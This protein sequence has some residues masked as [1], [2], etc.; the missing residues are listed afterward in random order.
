[1]K[2]KEIYLFFFLTFLNDI[3]HITDNCRVQAHGEKFH[4]FPVMTDGQTADD[5][6]KKIRKLILENKK[7]LFRIAMAIPN[8]YVASI[9]MGANMMQTLKVFKE[10][11]EHNG[12]AIIIA[13]SPCIEQGIYGGLNNSLEEQKL[14]VDANTN[15]KRNEISQTKF[16]NNKNNTSRIT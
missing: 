7:D 15:I 6:N 11:N 13:Y 3:R 16:E 10:A 9:S 12:P 14:L 8:V 1:M 4:F 2:A 5:Y